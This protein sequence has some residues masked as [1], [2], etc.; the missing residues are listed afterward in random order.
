MEQALAIND[1]LP[2]S[3]FV[4]GHEIVLDKTENPLRANGVLGVQD[5]EIHVTLRRNAPRNWEVEVSVVD[6]D[7]THRHRSKPFRTWGEGLNECEMVL[8]NPAWK[9]SMSP[10]AR[11]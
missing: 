2:A 9:K 4:F 7:R 3:V 1:D 6:E 10:A 5:I 8:A 11:R